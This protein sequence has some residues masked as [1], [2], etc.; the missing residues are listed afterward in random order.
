MLREKLVTNTD[1]L[2]DTMRSGN[3]IKLQ[4]LKNIKSE[5][6]R[7]EAGI[8]VLSDME[9]VNLIK[10]I[11]NNINETIKYTTDIND[12]N[13]LKEEI[14]YLEEF[15]PKQMNN[16]EIKKSI[17]DII[18]ENNFSSMRDMGN[19]MKVFNDKFKGLADNKVVS[20]IVKQLLS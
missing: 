6:S 11:I 19:A 14:T 8:K 12:I 17:L 4:V 7:K 10:S 18:T 15:V 5:I 20:D 3:S 2:K 16:D 9:I 1:L 13:I